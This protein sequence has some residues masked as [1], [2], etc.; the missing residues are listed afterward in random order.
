MGSIWTGLRLLW[1]SL[2]ICNNIIAK[3]GLRHIVV[4]NIVYQLDF[5][6]LRERERLICTKYELSPHCATVHSRPQVPLTL[7][8]F[9]DERKWSILLFFS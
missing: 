8:V 4:Y 5:S 9:S 3:K 1:E 2:R 6:A 7:S